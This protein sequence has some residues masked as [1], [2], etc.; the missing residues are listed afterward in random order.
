MVLD[1]TNAAAVVPCTAV[2]QA[3]AGATSTIEFREGFRRG[4][5]PGAGNVG[6]PATESVLA[7]PYERLARPPVLTNGRMS[8]GQRHPCGA[9]RTGR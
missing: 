6:L 3:H 8:M 1:Q 2:R 9:G 4:P 5:D 7:E